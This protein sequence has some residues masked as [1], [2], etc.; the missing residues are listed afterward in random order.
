[1]I[2]VIM[3][4]YYEGPDFI[5]AGTSAS[6]MAASTLMIYERLN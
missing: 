2:D 4:R 6:A 1:V 3:A 5:V